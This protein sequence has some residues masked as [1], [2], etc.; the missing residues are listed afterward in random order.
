VRRHED[1]EPTLERA[2]Y[3]EHEAQQALHRE[4]EQT[5]AQLG[6]A[7]SRTSHDLVA[8]Q[9]Q[10]ARTKDDLQTAV[11]ERSELRERAEGLDSAARQAR[12]ESEALQSELDRIAGQMRAALMAKEEAV[13][14]LERVQAQAAEQPRAAKG[15]SLFADED[16]VS[17]DAS[18]S[19]LIVSERAAA[20]GPRRI[21]EMLL[22]AGVIS[23]RQLDDA[24]A[25]QQSD[26]H[27]RLGMALLEIGAI[28]EPALA[29]ALALQAGI[30]FVVPTRESI[31][32]D[33]AR[34]L[35]RD[36]CTWQVVLP[37]R[38]EDNRMVVAMADPLDSET[39]A[40]VALETGCEVV[41]VSATA[42]DILA[43]IDLAF[44][45]SA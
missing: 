32:T 3:E 37:L 2:Q 33:S 1:Q 34:S 39:I 15:Y 42:T 7:A 19:A 35:P 20:G 14:E 29:Q 26:E 6:D 22:R 31:D 9:A 5:R 38:R 43:G 13:S 4:L 24:L 21:G 45:S 36:M 44:G 18:P 25:H 40:F 17:T 27:L 8:V 23:Q 10:L 30:Q 16:A 11:R 28:T 41:P 12:N